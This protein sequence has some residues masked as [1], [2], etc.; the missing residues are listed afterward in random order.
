MPLITKAP[1]GRVSQ[2]DAYELD[3]GTNKECH[4][5]PIAF[6]FLVNF[7]LEKTKGAFDPS[8]AQKK[9]RRER[10][11]KGVHRSIEE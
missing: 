9:P 10:A 1:V 8:G 2:W 6:L 5:F 4:K 11:L 7:T 3:S